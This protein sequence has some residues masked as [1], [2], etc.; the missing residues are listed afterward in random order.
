M[1]LATSDFRNPVCQEMRSL[2]FISSGGGG[3]GGGGIGGG[4]GSGADQL[5]SS[6]LAETRTS[7]VQPPETLSFARTYNEQEGYA[8]TYNEQ[9]SVDSSDTY[10]SCQTHPSHSQGDLTEEADSNLYVNPLEA[11]EKC[12]TGRVKKSISG[13]VGRNVSTDASPSIESLKEIRPFN[14]VSKVNLN[15][16]IPKHRKIR[17]QQS[18]K[19][20]AQFFGDQESMV[21]RG[22]LREDI[23]NL[24]DNNNHYRGLRGGRPSLFAPTNSLA[25]ATR[26]INHHLFGSLGG[27]KHYAGTSAESKLSLSADSID[28]DGMPFVDRHRASRSILK[29]SDSGNNYYSNTGDS[30][31]E[32]LITDSVSTASVCDNETTA[33][34]LQSNANV[35]RTRKRPVSPL[36]SRQVLES[37]FRTNNNADR[38][39]TSGERDRGRTSARTPKILFGDVEEEKHAR[40]EAVAEN[41]NKEGQPR[42]PKVRMQ[43][44]SRESQTTLIVRPGKTKK[45]PP[46]D[47]KKKASKSSGHGCA[48][49][50]STDANCLPQEYRFS[51]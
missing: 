12:G 2:R 8:K 39:Y 14:E 22:I 47:E 6:S 40:D 33:C 10:A 46:A 18:V 17:I 45:M 20:R 28:S 13:E 49:Y 50:K 48:T 36:L 7:P 44:E 43:E 35:S 11:T 42:R 4:S 5:V 25:S 3:G 51:W 9:G 23:A 32:K 31:T 37:M 16:T 29:K 26:I 27:P 38:E 34:E 24:E 15:D 1:P 19:P 30:D 41:Q 21:A